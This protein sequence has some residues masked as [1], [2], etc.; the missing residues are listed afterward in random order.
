MA[1]VNG[2]LHRPFLGLA[3][4]TVRA[5][6]SDLTTWADPHNSDPRFL[7]A[8]VR[9][10]VLP[11][12]ID[13]LGEAAVDGLAR[14]A[15][16]MRDDADA[17]DGWAAE[18]LDRSRL[19]DGTGMSAGVA[20]HL[21]VAA[22]EAVPRAVRTRVLRRAAVITGAPPG[23]LTREHIDAVEELVSR[24]RGQGPLALP[25]AVTAG[26]RYGRLYLEMSGTIEEGGPD[27]P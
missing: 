17:L 6:V 11:V 24:W 18:V 20:V 14:T 13:V 26:R 1:A 15:G 10:E 19:Q 8:R 22:L 23:A 7:R 4:A 2:D 5:T 16:L 21:D 25:G 27:A 9:A 12:L 3:R